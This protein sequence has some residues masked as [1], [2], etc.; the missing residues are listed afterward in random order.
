MIQWMKNSVRIKQLNMKI[1]PI[2]IKRY[3]VNTTFLF[4]ISILFI[5]INKV[6]VLF[7]YLL[8][9]MSQPTG[10]NKTG[11]EKNKNNCIVVLKTVTETNCKQYD[12]H[13]CVRK[14]IHTL[15]DG[16]DRAFFTQLHPPLQLLL[17]VLMLLANFSH[18]FKLMGVKST[19][20]QKQCDSSD[21][22][23]FPYNL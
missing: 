23:T 16:P 5:I 4:I 9:F 11:T 2:I 14:C 21:L 7:L 13:Q 12:P 1:I 15:A 20:F 8:L 19:K 18:E 22:V 6:F 10:K 3:V 17:W